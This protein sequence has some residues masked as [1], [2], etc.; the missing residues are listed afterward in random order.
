MKKNYMG[1]VKGLAVACLIFIGATQ[2]NAQLRFGLKGGFDVSNNRINKDI[3]NAHNRLGFQIGGTMELMAP[4]VGWGGELSV[5]YGHQ[6]YDVK[7][8]KESGTNYSLSDY[9]YLRVPLN[10]KKKFS[11]MGLFGVFIQAGPYA[12]FKLSGGDL[13]PENLDTQY[14]SKS[15]GAGINAGAGVE[16]LNHLELGMYYRKALTDNYSDNTGWGNILKK[17]PDNW[18]VNL[19]YFF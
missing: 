10:L 14:K 4:I 1:L 2:A 7:D 15:F 16:L 12:E 18:S 11:I 17:K 19:T 8:S 3:L 5:L 6:Q 13:K 9:N